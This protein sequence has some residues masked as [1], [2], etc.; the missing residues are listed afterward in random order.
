MGRPALLPAGCA[1]GNLG[2]R[3]SALERALGAPLVIRGPEGIHLRPLGESLVP[4]VQEM[5][6]V[7][8]DI[9]GRA[10]QRQARVRLAMPTGFTR[11]FTANLARLRA[12]EP[13][14]T[15]E[16][17]TGAKVIDL[18]MEQADLAIRS[19]PVL[20]Q[21][22]IAHPLGEPGWSLYASPVY[23]ARR[24]APVDPDDLSRHDI[25]GYD[26]T[27]SA[28]PAA[29]WIEQRMRGATL[30]WGHR[31]A[32]LAH[33]SARAT[34]SSRPRGDV[35]FAACNRGM[36]MSCLGRV[37]P[38]DIGNGRAQSCHLRRP[39]HTSPGSGSHLLIP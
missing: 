1:V 28:V 8:I 16:L 39:D 11:L 18:K 27:L 36:R 32:L 13:Q 20:D 6:R 5:G 10:T 12:A 7:A 38:V 4:R 30:G 37:E 15:L 23:L 22:L 14:L 26:L 29:M 9:R 35:G 2:R 19:G 21:D 24:P 33:S 3:L 25:I 34:A 17:L 31:P